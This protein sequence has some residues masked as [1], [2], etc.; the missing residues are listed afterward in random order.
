VGPWG[1]ADGQADVHAQKDAQKQ[2]AALQPAGNALRMVR[3][4]GG[5]RRVWHWVYNS[6]GRRSRARGQRRRCHF[7]RLRHSV[8]AMAAGAWGRVHELA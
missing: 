4:R 3:G 6:R 2:L 8:F 1:I 5:G 7:R